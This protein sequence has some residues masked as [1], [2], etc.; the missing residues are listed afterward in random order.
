MDRTAL[1]KQRKGTTPRAVDYAIPGGA[2]TLGSPE[3]LKAAVGVVVALCLMTSLVHVLFVFLHVAPSNEISQRYS[4]QVNAWI[5]PFF[6]QN[7]RLFAPEPE[8]VNRQISAR[9][10][11]TSADGVVHMSDWFD[12]TAVDDSAVTYNFFPSHTAHNMLRRAWGAYLETHGNDDQPHSQRAMM[13]QEYL[14][15]IAVDRVTAHRPGTFE[16]I[17]LRVITRP[18]APPT[19]ADKPRPAAPPAAQTR[20]LPWW[21]VTS[22]G[23]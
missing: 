7:W 15:N 18:I 11:R 2:Q 14:R 8:S 3:P 6:E 1:S 23:D 21:T 13:V 20:Q 10:M 4:P 9:T 17:Q 16:A 22:N 5:Y 19:T 12:L